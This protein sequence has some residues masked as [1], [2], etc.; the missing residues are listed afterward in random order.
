MRRTNGF[1]I[2]EM[3]IVITVIG[4]IIGGI[5]IGRDVIANA[6]LQ[7]I[8]SDV[9]RFK[10]AAKLFREKYQYLPGDL[11][12]ATTFW[13]T[14]GTCPGGVTS[15]YMPRVATCNGDGN[16]EIAGRYTTAFSSPKYIGNFY[17]EALR[18]WQH[19][20]NSGF[21]EGTYSGIPHVSGYYKTGINI[22]VSKTGNNNG[23]AMFYSGP[24][25]GSYATPGGTTYNSVFPS[26][27]GHIIEYGKAEETNA[28][29]SLDKPAL[30]AAHALN[31]DKKIDDGAP[32]EG[33]VVAYTRNNANT[34]VCVTTATPPAY[35]TGTAGII[36]S[37]I[38]I[39]GL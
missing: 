20:A 33:N 27:Y 25:N 34:P 8:I 23:Y 2:L 38:F 22:P 28:A 1:T 16:G 37:L 26:T 5:V 4:L 13:G 9:N 18:A 35:N 11:P 36:C 17:R 19:L 31:I 12:T 21:I 32:S 30:T 29:N 39:T 14:D 7:T 15:N 24:I 10:N 3:S 6:E